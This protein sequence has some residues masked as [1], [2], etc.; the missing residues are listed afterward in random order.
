MKAIINHM[1]FE[2]KS[3]IRDK[4]LLLMNYLFPLAFYFMMQAIMPSI[5]KEFSEY[6]IPG[7]TVFAVMV[8]TLL[9]MHCL[10]QMF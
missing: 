10:K 7:M 3:I 1:G 4:T 5:N 9:G 6:M 8:S 2:F